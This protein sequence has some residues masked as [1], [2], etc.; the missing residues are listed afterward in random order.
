MPTAQVACDS[1][2]VEELQV[3][4]RR[5]LLLRRRLVHHE[6]LA[7]LTLT[8]PLPLGARHRPDA[9][10]EFGVRC[11]PPARS[12]SCRARRW[13]RSPSRALPF[14]MPSRLSNALGRC[15]GSSRRGRPSPCPTSSVKISRPVASLNTALV[16]RAFRPLLLFTKSLFAS[17]RQC[18]KY[19]GSTLRPEPRLRHGTAALELLG[20]GAHLVERRRRL[21]G[22]EPGLA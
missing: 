21:L 4:P 9:E 14:P 11:R 10:L 18:W 1:G 7:A 15:R 2:R 5:R 13:C 20:G 12:R 8:P 16:A 19:P 3:L 22:I 6:E 17:A